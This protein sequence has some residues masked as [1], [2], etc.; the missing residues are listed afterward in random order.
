MI[1]PLTRRAEGLSDKLRGT[2]QI[3]AEEDINPTIPLIDR[4]IDSLGAM[5]VTSWLVQ[6]KHSFAVVF[7]HC[8]TTLSDCMALLAGS[9]S[10]YVLMCQS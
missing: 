2:L 5:T 6:H 10:S 3:P 8:S 4:G 9:Q 1:N 7:I